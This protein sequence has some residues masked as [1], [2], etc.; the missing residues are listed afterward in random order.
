M[1]NQFW[2]LTTWLLIFFGVLF[3][4]TRILKNWRLGLYGLLIF[5][6][7]AGLPTI[8]LY[9]APAW[10]RLIKDIL[11]VMPLY[12]AF[13]MWA[14]FADRDRKQPFSP[15]SLHVLLALLAFLMFIHLWN[16][17]LAN[18]W[19]GLIGIKLW[20]FY[21]PLFYLGYRFLDK[22]ERLF[23]VAK[24]MM[25]VAVIPATIGIA[26]AVVIYFGYSE[27]VY[28]V[29]G[30]AA[31]SATQ[32]FV[33]LGITG[34]QHLIRIPSTFTSAAQYSLFLLGMLP[35]GYALWQASRD[36]RLP[37]GRTYFGILCLL[38]L[39]ALTCGSRGAL[40]L[41]PLYF[42][43]V[44]VIDGR[45]IS[46]WKLIGATTLGFVLT[47]SLLG[48]AP[49]DLLAYGLDVLWKYTEGRQKGGVIG[50]FGWAFNL[51][52]LGWGPGMSSG[53]ARYAFN[54]PET[55]PTPLVPFEGFYAK[56][57]AELGLAGLAI[58]V[59]FFVRLS[60]AGCHVLAR[61]REPMLRPFAVAFLAFLL[62]QIV[63]LVKGAYL[64]YD[65]LN[66]YFWLFAGMLMKLPA[67]SSVAASESSL[68]R[69]RMKKILP[70]HDLA[71]VP[72][73]PGRSL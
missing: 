69:S 60:L 37:G 51:T 21:V 1:S 43:T 70:G 44:V 34:G 28:K 55:E 57:T 45:W 31:E 36:R 16:P 67:L 11:F 42:A 41:A 46:H 32:N 63:Y 54:N 12:G 17:R 39:A 71:N 10:T 15:Q 25:A 8:F 27:A 26:E 66:V 62:V 7:F 64:D 52:W 4:Y 6:P 53:P 13:L 47:A 22:P 50:E 61:V 56:T 73:Q 14:L 24:V 59:V 72:V 5:L 29:Y 38:V 35:V 19:V 23:T 49:G 68:L 65:P 3:L 40:L 9:P 30:A 48:V 20:L 33:K 2:F 58:V 18:L